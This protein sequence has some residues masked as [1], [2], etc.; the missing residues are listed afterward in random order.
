[1]YH[2]LMNLPVFATLGFVALLAGPLAN[3]SIVSGAWICETI[4]DGGERLARRYLY[5]GRRNRV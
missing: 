4:V 2:L 5:T 1:M 3:L